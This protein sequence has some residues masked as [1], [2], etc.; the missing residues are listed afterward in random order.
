MK[1]VV[2]LLLFAT[3]FVNAF[4]QQNT[5]NTSELSVDFGSFRNRYLFPITNIRYQS[6]LLNAIDLNFSARL[7]SYGSLFFWSK[8]AYDLTLWSEYYFTLK[9]D[10]LK[11]STGLGMDTHFNLIKDIRSSAFS[12]VAPLASVS[13]QCNS[14]AFKLAVPLWSRFYSNGISLS[15]LP[16]ISFRATKKIKVFTRYEISHLMV[17]QTGENEWQQDI[18][19]GAGISW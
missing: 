2:F 12:S 8:S 14:N 3:V 4:G 1:K 9:S 10:R 6:A 15:A 7:R 16:E 19:I 18:F 11:V 5:E 17:Y 13:V